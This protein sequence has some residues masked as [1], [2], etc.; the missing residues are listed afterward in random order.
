MCITVR[1]VKL[2]IQNLDL[3]YSKCYFNKGLT[4]FG[5]LIL[6]PILFFFWLKLQVSDSLYSS[7]FHTFKSHFDGEKE[8]LISVT[9]I[10][11][12][13]EWISGTSSVLDH[14]LTF[15]LFTQTN[16]SN[17]MLMHTCMN[18]KCISINYDFHKTMKAVL[19]GSSLAQTTSYLSCQRRMTLNRWHGKIWNIHT[20]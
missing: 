9:P 7:P 18:S 20:V 3:K 2:W 8:H 11:Q 19:I 12:S 5:R 10:L 13:L 15:K 14:S 4:R 16:D 6:M 1:T 17:C